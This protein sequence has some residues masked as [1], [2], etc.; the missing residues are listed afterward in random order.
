MNYTL[1]KL[2]H[3]IIDDYSYFETAEERL[4]WVLERTPIY[5]KLP[6]E[7]V[8]AEMKVPECISGLWIKGVESAGKLSFSAHSDSSLVNGLAC[9][10]CDL[11]S[12][13]EAKQILE[14]GTSLV[15]ELKL[16]GL[17]TTNRKHAVQK[18][19]AFMLTFANNTLTNTQN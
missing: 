9:L 6:V 1:N 11:Y 12:G 13:L 7:Q 14:Y 8:S 4:T 15:S 18:I 10:I 5:P 16:E 3:E 17:L 19:V 2:Q